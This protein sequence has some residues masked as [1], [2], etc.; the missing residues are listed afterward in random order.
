M[1]IDRKVRTS[2]GPRGMA[3][4]RNLAVSALRVAGATNVAQAIRHPPGTPFS[5]SHYC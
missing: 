4:L 3:S 1:K 5:P 2:N